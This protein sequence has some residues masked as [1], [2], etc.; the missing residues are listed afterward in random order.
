VEA[1]DEA[2]HEGSIDKKLK[3]VEDFD[4]RIVSP[5]LKHAETS[6]E[7]FTILVLPDHPTPISLKTHTKDPIPFAIYRTDKKDSDGAE[8]F[9]EDSVKNGSLGLVKGSDLIRMIVKF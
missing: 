1:P 8:A 4:S 3:A 7:P 2:G 9:D 5:I 6:A